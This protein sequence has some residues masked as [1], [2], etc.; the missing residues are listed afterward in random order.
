M[1]ERMRSREGG[2]MREVVVFTREQTRV[3]AKEDKLCRELNTSKAKPECQ[4]TNK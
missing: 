2:R 1:Q 3:R 4:P